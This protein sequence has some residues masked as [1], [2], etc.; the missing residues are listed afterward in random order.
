MPN[1]MLLRLIVILTSLS[2]KG[3]TKSRSFVIVSRPPKRSLLANDDRRGLTTP[4]FMRWCRACEHACHAHFL[5]S[6]RLHEWE[7]S[8]AISETRTAYDP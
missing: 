1:D 5:L 2:I 7:Y 4:E 8:H 6:G 3:N